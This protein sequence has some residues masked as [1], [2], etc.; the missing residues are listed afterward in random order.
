MTL[1]NRSHRRS[2]SR[3]AGLVRFIVGLL[4][5]V[6]LVLLWTII[7]GIG[8]LAGHGLTELNTK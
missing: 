7:D 1:P 8:T 4:I 5:V 2:P 3:Y 6:G